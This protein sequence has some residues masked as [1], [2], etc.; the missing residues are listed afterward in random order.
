[1]NAKGIALVGNPSECIANLRRF[2]D[3]GVRYFTLGFVPI[4]SAQTTIRR[5]TLF[6]KE[7]MPAFR[8]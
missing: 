2:T 6:A 7:V 5:L 1:M 8:E 4:A 3:I